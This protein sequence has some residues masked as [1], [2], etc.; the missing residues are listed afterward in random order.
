MILSFVVADWCVIPFFFII[1]SCLSQLSKN[2]YRPCRGSTMVD[3]SQLSLNVTSCNIAFSKETS[4]IMFGLACPNSL[5]KESVG[6]PPL[7]QTFSTLPIKA[8]CS[9]LE[10][11][12]STS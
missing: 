6:N 12:K 4:S 7:N 10:A 2:A 9:K 5:L 8:Q 1:L 3:K 11:W